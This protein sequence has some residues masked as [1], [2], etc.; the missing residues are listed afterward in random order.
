[1]KNKTFLE[2]GTK[3]H[4]AVRKL[5]DEICEILHIDVICK[6]LSKWLGDK[7]VEN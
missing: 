6:K 7:D 5:F 2:S 4:N 1:M 3:L